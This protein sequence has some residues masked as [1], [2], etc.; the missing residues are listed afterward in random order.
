MFTQECLPD[1]RRANACLL[2]DRLAAA[3]PSETGCSGRRIYFEDSH[4]LEYQLGLLDALAVLGVVTLTEGGSAVDVASPM[5]G[6][7]L[8]LLS[9]LLDTGVPLLPDWQTLG[10]GQSVPTTLP[11][12]AANLLA[13]LEA[14]RLELLPDAP[15]MRETEAAVGIIARQDESAELTFLLVYDPSAQAWQLPGGRCE[16]FDHSPRATLMRELCEELGASLHEPH[17]LM[18]HDLATPISIR[19]L[20]PTYGLLTQT[21]FHPFV[22]WLQHPVNL[23][24]SSSCWLPLES[25]RAGVAPDNSSVAAEPLLYLL[26]LP[27][28]AIG[29]LL[30]HESLVAESI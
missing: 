30:M 24:P 29:S 20:S 11:L 9:D 16:R 27:G 15:P 12:R 3:A 22:V 5:A 8:R 1:V 2:L 18:L 21:L 7:A 4:R 25:I 26:D 19:R 17:D 13:F 23:D 6:W 28:S 14:R 10:M